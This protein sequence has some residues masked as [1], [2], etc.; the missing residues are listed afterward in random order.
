MFVKYETTANQKLQKY[1]QSG[2]V[3]LTHSLQLGLDG[4]QMFIS[5]HCPMQI[6][7]AN[8]QDLET[9]SFMFVLGTATF[10]HNVKNYFF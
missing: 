10:P 1:S 9:V 4:I 2:T 7:Q 6:S 3:D 5:Q 8:T